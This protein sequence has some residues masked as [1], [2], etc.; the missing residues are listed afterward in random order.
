MKNNEQVY[1][2]QIAPLMKQIIEICKREKMPMFADFQ[3]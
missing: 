3:M 2:E 1:D